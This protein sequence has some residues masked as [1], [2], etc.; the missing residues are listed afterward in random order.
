MSTD[1]TPLA[2]NITAAL[3]AAIAAI[4]CAILVLHL[5]DRTPAPFW[6]LL[7]VLLP[8]FA[9]A[10]L[11][12]TSDVEAPAQQIVLYPLIVLAIWASRPGM[13]LVRTIGLFVAL[14]AG[15]SLLL[16]LLG[17]GLVVFAQYSAVPEK[18]VIGETLL[19]GPYSHSNQLA[20]VLALGLPA[21]LQLL[22]TPTK[23]L[24][25][26]VV[27][28]ALVW[29][30]S[31]TAL[32][33]AAIVLIAHVVVKNSKTSKGASLLAGAG[34]IGLAAV[35]VGLPFLNSDSDA[36]AARGAI[37]QYGLHKWRED[38]LVGSGPDVFRSLNE[39]TYALGFFPTHGHNMLVES[40]ATGGLI[41][42]LLFAIYTISIWVSTRDSPLAAVGI[43]W[44]IS[45]L[46]IGTLEASANY[47]NIGQ[48]G[49]L[50]WTIPTIV[51]CSWRRGE[52]SVIQ[53]RRPPVATDP[54]GI[55]RR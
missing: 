24:S 4:A 15:L 6:S 17:P 35:V 5:R 2:S 23:V 8:W 10:V 7:V 53:S 20:I 37:W 25:T 33:V 29:T 48:L 12:L 1:M 3:A 9:F 52:A 47:S 11:P 14:T 43:L 32:V 19:A 39:T 36:F 21:V 28:S 55:N 22:K 13:E 26:L 18:A 50:T 46:G 40:L 45:F 30:A 51:I 27:L 42:T 44:V 38:P 54:A 16:G 41:G 49:F 31:R 34:A